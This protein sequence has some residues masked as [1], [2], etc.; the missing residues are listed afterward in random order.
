[1]IPDPL[2]AGSGDREPAGRETTHRANGLG[3]RDGRRPP[4]GR[5]AEA[6]GTGTPRKNR[7]PL[8]V[9]ANAGER[10]ERGERDDDDT[11]TVFPSRDVRGDA[12]AH[13]A[14]TGPDL[15]DGESHRPE[16][17]PPAAP[18]EKKKHASG[19]YLTARH[20][21]RCGGGSPHETRLFP[22]PRTTTTTGPEES[23]DAP[24]PADPPPRRRRRTSAKPPA[25]ARFP[26]HAKPGL[27]H[28][29][30]ARTHRRDRRARRRRRKAPGGDGPRRVRR[31][32]GRRP[33]AVLSKGRT[34]ERGHD[35]AKPEPDPRPRGGT[36]QPLLPNRGNAAGEGG[37]RRPPHGTQHERRTHATRAARP[38]S[39]GT[40]KTGKRGRDRSRRGT[41]G[42][43]VGPGSPPPPSPVLPARL[44]VP[45]EVR[46]HPRGSGGNRGP[47][48]LGRARTRP[49]RSPPRVTRPRLRRAH[50][51]PS[52]RHAL[53]PRVVPPRTRSEEAR[54]A[55]G[56]T[57]NARVSPP[58]DGTWRG[59]PG[60]SYAHREVRACQGGDPKH[61]L[62]SD[63]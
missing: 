57:E 15:G 22:P 53:L 2:R 39:A 42:G 16:P 28:P 54:A 27:S 32:A 59:A 11:R 31:R 26:K 9:L 7:G 47:A 4:P 52:S 29:L 43:R 18:E 37:A 58:K 21:T 46:A 25:L 10:Q 6:E 13:D 40:A 48:A 38:R 44:R 5:E 19:G 3:G 14:R 36:G 17:P 63:R 24:Q 56:D 1:M 61:A 33:T 50:G 49:L 41:D 55:S 62:S 20:P 60:R 8:R 45:T 30:L 51:T 12:A 23:P 34:R 35:P